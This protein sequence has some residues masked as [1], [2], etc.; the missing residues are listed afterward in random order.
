MSLPLEGKARCQDRPVLE[1]QRLKAKRV[2][3]MRS[4][5][6]DASTHAL[7]R[8]RAWQLLLTSDQFHW[9]RSP[10]FRPVC[11]AVISFFFTLAFEK[12]FSCRI[13]TPSIWIKEVLGYWFDFDLLYPRIGP[14]HRITSSSVG[15]LI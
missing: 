5:K 9:R 8:G 11:G 7:A 6:Q 15:F 12:P 2:K 3:L 4:D 1:V 13:T 10:V 14:W